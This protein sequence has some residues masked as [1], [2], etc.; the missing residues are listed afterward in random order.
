M[1]KIISVKNLRKAYRSEKVFSRNETKTGIGRDCVRTAVRPGS[2]G[3]V[4]EVRRVFPP[5][6]AGRLPGEYAHL[7]NGIYRVITGFPSGSSNGVNPP[8]YPDWTKR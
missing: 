6:D 8:A 2:G 5:D 3:H 4:N 7:V 1:E